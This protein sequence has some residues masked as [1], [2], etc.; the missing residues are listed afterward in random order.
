MNSPPIDD[1][2]DANDH[3]QSQADIWLGKLY[4]TFFSLDVVVLRKVS[5]LSKD[6]AIQAKS[7]EQ[8]RSWIF[9]G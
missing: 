1:L 6:P 5:P 7:N 3:S 2:Q 9:R 8:G 4:A